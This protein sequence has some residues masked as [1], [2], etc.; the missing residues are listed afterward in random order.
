MDR[1]FASQNA[2]RTWLPADQLFRLNSSGV[3]E[4]TPQGIRSQLGLGG[5]RRTDSRQPSH[6]GRYCD[7]D[8][9]NDRLAASRHRAILV[10][11]HTNRNGVVIVLLKVKR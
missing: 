8:E 6:C 5:L 9:L 3:E 7:G 2:D 4:L 1:L 10:S 11:S